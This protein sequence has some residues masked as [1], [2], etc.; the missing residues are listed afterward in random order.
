MTAAQ[1]QGFS[2]EVPRKDSACSGTPRVVTPK[3]DHKPAIALLRHSSVAERY[4]WK[5]HV[6]L[7]KTQYNKYF[8]C[9]AESDLAIP[10]ILNSSMYIYK[11]VKKS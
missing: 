4:K 5:H 2:E 7:R 9:L 1:P 3:Q 8:L 10:E 11:I 6:M